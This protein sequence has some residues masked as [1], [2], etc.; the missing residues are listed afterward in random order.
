MIDADSANKAVKDGLVATCAWCERLWES[1]DRTGSLSCG[2]DCGG[3]M[4]GRGFPRY[5]GPWGLGRARF[6]FKCGA[7]ATSMAEFRENGGASN[8]I[9]ICEDHME[10]LKEIVGSRRGTIVKEKKISILDLF[11]AEAT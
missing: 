8:M 1:R 6:C 9:G 4:S 5:K 10:V 7:E 11:D 3:P 2:E